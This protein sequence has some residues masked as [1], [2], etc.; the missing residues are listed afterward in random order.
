MFSGTFL[1]RTACEGVSF[2]ALEECQQVWEIFKM[3]M[4]AIYR[5]KVKIY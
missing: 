2:A 4:K 3:K 1:E 5:Q